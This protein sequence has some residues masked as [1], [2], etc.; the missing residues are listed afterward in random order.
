MHT[1]NDTLLGH[2]KDKMTPSAATVFFFFKLLS[3]VRLLAP[4]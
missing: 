1:Y 2:E 4:V 3:R